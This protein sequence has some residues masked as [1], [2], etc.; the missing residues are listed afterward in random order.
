M[1]AAAQTAQ[2]VESVALLR[3]L[4]L[5]LAPPTPETTEE[6][7][8]LAAAL[9]GQPGSPGELEQLRAAVESTPL[10][11][12]VAAHERLFDGDVAVPP[13]EGSYELDPFRQTR[14]MA[15]VAGFYR[16]FGADV[17]GPAI[18]RAD[19]AGAELEFLAFLGLRRIEAAEAGRDDEATHCSEIEV[20]FLTEHAGRWLPVFFAGLADRAPDA[21]HHALG[22]IGARVV[23][24]ELDA[25]GLDID[26]V[27]ADRRPLTAVEV[28]E[29]ECGAADLADPLGLIEP[30][31]A[32]RRRPRG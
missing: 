4:S 16:A 3:L 28:D 18:E 32:K 12:L 26:Q 30:H 10:D 22:R 2:G 25:R 9:A 5:A 17:G 11:D 21:F 23:A 6:V 27:P 7:G 1:T 20:A 15:D 31:A 29:M 19:H 14:Q 8:A 24:A 13:Y